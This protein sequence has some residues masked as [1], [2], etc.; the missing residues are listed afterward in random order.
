MRIPLKTK[1]KRRTSQEIAL[2]DAIRHLRHTGGSL[3]SLGRGCR[4]KCRDTPFF[5]IVPEDL[6][7]DSNGSSPS[8]AGS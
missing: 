6:E 3:E 4:R 8:R 2:Q 7:E 1:L 5:R